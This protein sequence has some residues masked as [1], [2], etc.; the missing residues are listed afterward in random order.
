M[1]STTARCHFWSRLYISR[2]SCCCFF[3][4]LRLSL[5]FLTD[6]TSD[7]Y[8]AMWSYALPMLFFFLSGWAYKETFFT[9][10]PAPTCLRVAAPAKA[11]ASAGRRSILPPIFRFRRPHLECL[12]GKYRHFRPQLSNVRIPVLR[13]GLKAFKSCTGFLDNANDT[14]KS[15]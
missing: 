7:T 9:D 10:L 6:F 13:L 3:Q 11:G 12:K 2:L 8:R 1:R 4:A 5:E 14:I 15:A